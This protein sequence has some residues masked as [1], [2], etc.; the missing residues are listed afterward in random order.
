MRFHSRS[1]PI[2]ASVCS[3]TTDPRKRATSSAVYG[4]S[5]P[6]QRSPSHSCAIFCVVPFFPFSTL[7]SCAICFRYLHATLCTYMRIYVQRRRG[8]RP[9]PAGLGTCPTHRGGSGGGGRAGGASARRPAAAARRAPRPR[10]RGSRPPR[11]GG[12]GGGGRKVVPSA[13]RPL[14]SSRV[15]SGPL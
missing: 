3:M 4:R 6:A 1:A 10:R 15:I 8:S 2:R 7:S 12:G 13:R 14:T 11:R 5:T 9:P